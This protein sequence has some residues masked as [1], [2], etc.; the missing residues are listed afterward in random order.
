MQNQFSLY[1]PIVL[2]CMIFG[3]QNKNE[4]RSIRWRHVENGVWPFLCEQLPIICSAH[5]LA[6]NENQ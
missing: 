5:S 3:K 4:Q 6:V 2:Y 1:L